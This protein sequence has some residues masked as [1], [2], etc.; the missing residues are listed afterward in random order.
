MSSKADNIYIVGGRVVTRG[1]GCIL[2]VEFS[3]NFNMMFL[4]PNFSSIAYIL[5][6]GLSFFRK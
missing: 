2:A 3:K 5:H 4:L 6:N 1:L